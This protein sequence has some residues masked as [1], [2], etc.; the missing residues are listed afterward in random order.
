MSP[1]AP[2]PSPVTTAMRVLVSVVLLAVGLLVITAP[3]FAFGQSFSA[4]VQKW[5]AGWIGVV[6]GYWLA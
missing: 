4:D 3:N 5:A 1:G 2:P 6:V